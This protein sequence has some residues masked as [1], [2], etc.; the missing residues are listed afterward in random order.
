MGIFDV[1]GQGTRCRTRRDLDPGLVQ[2]VG[3]SQ[4]APFLTP[5][6]QGSMWEVQDVAFRAYLERKV[7]VLDFYLLVL[8]E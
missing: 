2:T 5:E 4:I 7:V 6:K 3:I 8:R 1:R